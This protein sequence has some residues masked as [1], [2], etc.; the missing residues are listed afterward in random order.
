MTSTNTDD[1]CS[2]L[3]N[4][5]RR[6]SAGL[7]LQRDR[8]L[9][10][11]ESA[12]KLLAGTRYEVTDLTTTPDNDLDFYAYELGRLQDIARTM[13]KKF[14]KPVELTAALEAFETAIP[15]LRKA[16]NPLTHI[17]GRPRLDNVSWFS[18]LVELGPNGSVEYLIDPRYQQHD[19]A[20][21]LAA[22]LTGY[23][24]AQLQG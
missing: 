12:P 16:R 24:R 22:T 9:A 13:I 1:F 6:V 10:S 8:I 20:R 7:E 11:A 18:A 23:L 3:L 14:D 2:R 19:A 17:D 15:N 4:G 21:R 5:L